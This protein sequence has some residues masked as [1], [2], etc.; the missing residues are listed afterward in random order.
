MPPPGTIRPPPRGGSSRAPACSRR[1]W[2]PARTAPELP[3][4]ARRVLCQRHRVGFAEARV[5]SSRPCCRSSRSHSIIPLPGGA[6]GT[7]CASRSL[8]PNDA[9]SDPAR[10]RASA[11]CSR[12][13]SPTISV[14]S[15]VYSGL[16]AACIADASLVAAEGS[17]PVELSAN[18]FMRIPSRVLRCPSSG[19]G[20]GPRVGKLRMESSARRA[21][22]GQ[23]RTAASRANASPVLPSSRR[24]TGPQRGD[25]ITRSPSP[26]KPS[27]GR[28]PDVLAGPRRERGLRPARG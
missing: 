13:S 5:S 26:Q 12:P 7:T 9:C 16:L 15:C 22:Y 18:P 10:A 1:A 21:R 6:G 17:T 3:G 20:G 11:S 27:A 4:T 2:R 25:P 19:S 8:P 14:L 23:Q 24:A 28:R